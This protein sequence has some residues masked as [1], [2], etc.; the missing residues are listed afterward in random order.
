MDA[1]LRAACFE[2][3]RE[4]R[5][6]PT[7]QRERGGIGRSNVTRKKKEERHR[8]REGGRKGGRERLTHHTDGA[9]HKTK[10]PPVHPGGGGGNRNNPRRELWTKDTDLVLRDLVLRSGE[11]DWNKIALAIEWDSGTVTPAECRER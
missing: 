11:V 8:G 10:M 7:Q 6:D 3:F 9:S 1:L 4:R 5:K 2:G